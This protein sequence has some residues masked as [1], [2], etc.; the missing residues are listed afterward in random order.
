MTN[1]LVFVEQRESAIKKYSL[2]VLSEGVRLAGRTGGKVAAVCIGSEEILASLARFGCTTVY[3]SGSDELAAYSP[4]GYTELVCQAVTRFQPGV[5]LAAASAMGKDLLPRVAARLDVAV[6]QDC[7]GIQSDAE[8]GF[9]WVRPIFAGKAYASVS[10]KG[11]P[12]VATLRPNVFAIQEME[13]PAACEHIRLDSE[14]KLSS[15][16]ARVVETSQLSGQTLELTEADMIVSGGRGLKGPEHFHLVEELAAALGAAVGASRAVVD[17]GWK[18]HRFQVGQT[19]KTVSPTLYI[20]CGISGAIQHLA[21]MSSSK[22]IVAINKDPEAPI[23]KLA[24]FGIVGDL[25]Q[26]L[27]AITEELKRFKG[28]QGA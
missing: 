23:F 8:G 3:S 18:E 24:D 7:T 26:V 16:R 4:E 17:A 20:A 27:P 21:G 14:L 6:A 10:L 5:L 12:Q 1:I 15:I 28:L 25:F 11:S 19:G 2:E 9:Q 13:S 22:Y